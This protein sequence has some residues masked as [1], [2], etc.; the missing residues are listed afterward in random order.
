VSS[1]AAENPE[2]LRDTEDERPTPPPIGDAGPEFT[3]RPR[4]RLAKSQHRLDETCEFRA[5]VVQREGEIE[6]LLV[7]HCQLSPTRAS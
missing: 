4:A 6:R 2:R 5:E 3:E 7:A 1:A